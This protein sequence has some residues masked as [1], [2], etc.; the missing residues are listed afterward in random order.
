[1]CKKAGARILP[2]DIG[3]AG[4]TKVP[5]NKVA[6]GTRN[7]AKEPAMRQE[8]SLQNILVGPDRGEQKRQ[9][10]RSW[11]PEKMGIGNTPATRCLRLF[12]R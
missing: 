7:F 9:A 8:Q 3:M 5:D 1:M 12:F 2:I 10:W 4:K 11:P 6:C